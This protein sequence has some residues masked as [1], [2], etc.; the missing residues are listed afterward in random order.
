MD[1]I[2]ERLRTAAEG[3]AKA[4]QMMAD[5]KSR[6]NREAGDE[7]ACYTGLKREQTAEWKAAELLER[8][9]A[10]LREIAD[11][12]AGSRGA[13]A[14]FARAHHVAKAALGCG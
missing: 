10:A 8:Y 4:T 6:R 1:R 7:G 3:V 2:P 5:A 11:M 9:E 14:K 12:E 13:Y